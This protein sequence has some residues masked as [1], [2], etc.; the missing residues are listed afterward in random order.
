MGIFY[1]FPFFL[2]H[3]LNLYPDLYNFFKPVVF[4]SVDFFFVLIF[5]DCNSVI[6]LLK[7]EAWYSHHSTRLVLEL[8]EDE[9]HR[10]ACKQARGSREVAVNVFLHWT[11]LMCA[12]GNKEKVT[13]QR[14]WG[15]CYLGHFILRFYSTWR[16]GQS[17][18]WRI[19]VDDPANAWLRVAGGWNCLLKVGAG[20]REEE[21]AL[22]RKIEMAT[23]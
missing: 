9:K 8:G 20:L 1:S 7:R 21:N 3:L 12:F 19:T 18:T 4:Q 11:K 15:Q 10:K 23:L 22:G 2:N 17:K 16:I 5:A 6:S 14:H 13:V